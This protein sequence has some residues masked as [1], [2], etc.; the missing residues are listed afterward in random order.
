MRIVLS[1]KG[2]D[3]GAGGVPSPIINNAPISLPIP[4]N[5]TMGTPYADLGLG[6]TVHTLTKGR[7]G[8]DAIAHHDPLFADQTVFFGQAGAAQA[9][10]DNQGVEPGDVFL[11]FGLFCD[12]N[13][14]G[15]PNGKPHHRIFGW[16]RAEHK[17]P[18]RQAAQRWPH[19]RHPHFGKERTAANDTLWAGT[20][21]QARAALPGL[22]LTEA[23]AAPSFWR[24]PPWIRHAGMSYHDTTKRWH[25]DGRIQ[26]VARGQEFVIGPHAASRTWA[27]SIIA[28]C[29]ATQPAH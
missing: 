16:M 15:H 26:V 6:D 27:E 23:N 10:L 14:K 5:D 28:L 18:A 17:M 1:R 2:F 9:H 21:G 11:F 25:Q 7:I 24:L 12:R 19:L 22:R 20:G 3:T 13:A 4:Q 8:P 29:N